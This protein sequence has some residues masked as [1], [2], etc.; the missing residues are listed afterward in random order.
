MAVPEVAIL[1]DED[2]VVCVRRLAPGPARVPIALP[3]VQ[4]VKG[5]V[6]GRDERPRQPRRKL[7]VKEKLHPASG[8]RRF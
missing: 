5:I 1:G 2:P 4:C 3:K 7:R 6:P 8:I